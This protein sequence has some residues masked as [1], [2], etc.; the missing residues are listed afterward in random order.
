MPLRLRSQFPFAH[1]E[2]FQH[3]R[4]LLSDAHIPLQTTAFQC[5]F[6]PLRMSEHHWSQRQ[7]RQDLCHNKEALP[8]SRLDK[9][10]FLSRPLP[11]PIAREFSRCHLRL[12]AQFDRD[13]RQQHQSHDRSQPSLSYCPCCPYLS[14]CDAESNARRL[15]MK[16]KRKAT[17]R[18]NQSRD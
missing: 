1:H 4:C 3:Q 8:H 5:E 14:P 6:L 17:R 9:K 2:R 16:N 18:D 15:S 10:V 7:N 13:Y 12:Q 11:L